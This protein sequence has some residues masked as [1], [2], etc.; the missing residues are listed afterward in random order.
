MP[1]QRNKEA[2]S[3]FSWVFMFLLCLQVSLNSQTPKGEIKTMPIPFPDTETISTLPPDGGSEFNRLVFEKSPYLLQHC[4]NP[5]DWY[6]WGD[7]AFD[8]A[9]RTG[10]PIFLSIGYATCHWCHVME[11]ESFE[12]PEVAAL[13]NANFVCIKVDREERPDIDTVYMTV[14]QALTG[15]GGW[16][17]TVVMTADKEPFFAGTYFPKQSKYGR[18]GMME[19]LPRIHEF[20]STEKDR[21][22]EMAREITEKIKS[23]RVESTGDMP[24][25]KVLDLAFRGLDQSFDSARGGFGRSPKFPVP[26]NLRFLIRY[27]HRTGKKRA[28]KMAEETL[29]AMKNGGIYDHVGFGF[30]RYSTDADW[31]LPH[32]E[33]MLYDQALL[34]LA[35]LEGFEYTKNPILSQTVTEILDYIQRDMT[36]EEGGFYS[37]EDADS[38]GEEGKFYVWTREEVLNILGKT[39]GELFCRI[40]RV[41]DGGNFKDEATGHKTGQNILHR[42]KTL[43]EWAKTLEI[44]EIKLKERLEASRNKLFEVREKRVHPLKDDKILTDWNG[45]MISAFARAGSSLDRPELVETG[46]KAADFVLNHLKTKEGH[47]LKRYRKGDAGLSAH[48]EDYAFFVSGLIDLYQAC[49]E[50]KYLAEA[51]ALSDTM[52]ALFYDEEQGGF[53]Q[54]SGEDETLFFRPK[55]GYDGATPSGNSVAAENLL[56]LSRLTGRQDYEEKAESALK[57]FAGSIKGPFMGHSHL[58]IALDFAIGPTAEITLAGDREDPGLEQMI[59]Q[60]ASIYEPLKV[61]LV[62]PGKASE[63]KTLIEKLAPF[64]IGQVPIDDKAT[65]Y[66]CKNFACRQPT[67]DPAAMLRSLSETLK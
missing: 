42:D 25:E 59:R 26:H 11:H 55:E 41:L 52:I 1:D 44:P 17:M 43:E 8:E 2:P 35:Y 6:P 29:I 9:K 24:G 23:V 19:L 36:S 66:V 37:A 65:A 12:D 56:R 21:A 14:T 47:L 4:R 16:P 3:L 60:L 31:L 61:V 10:K 64:L 40:Y 34:A 20:W 5:V 13:M 7:E 18:I 28:A 57:L 48:L 54:T 39:E 63:G 30:H 15:S 33:K 32:F 53:F 46:M 62:H 49:F 51:V 27:A 38:E 45:L 67:S 50:P 22:V 58:M